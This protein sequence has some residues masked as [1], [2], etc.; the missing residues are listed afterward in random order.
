MKARASQQASTTRTVTANSLWYGLDSILGL[1]MVFL[2]S[3]PLARALGPE[4]LGYF[5]YVGW[6]CAMSGNLG[7][8][9]IPGTA[10]RF[11]ALYLGRS[12]GG[13]ARA[14]FRFAIRTQAITAAVLTIGGALL[15]LEFGDPQYRTVTLLQVA[16]ILPAMLGQ[17]ATFANMASEKLSRNVSGGL[18][19]NVVYLSGVWASL[20]FGWGLT[21]VAAAMLLSKSVE[22]ALR[23]GAA[24]QWIGAHAEE[25][26]SAEE[27][28]PMYR[29][30]GQ[31]LYVGL[32]AAI[33]WSKSDVVLLKWLSR[34]I[35]QVTFFTLACNIIDK[36]VTLPQIIGSAM[37]ISMVAQTGDDPGRAAA[38]TATATRYMFLLSAPLLFG[39]F[40]VASPAVRILYGVQYAETAPILALGAVLAVTKPLLNPPDALFRATGR[41]APMLVCATACTV[42]NM[43]LDVL[44]IPG[45][46]ALGATVGNGVSQAVLVI[47]YLAIAV[48]GFGVRMD[49]RAAAMTAL[50]AGAMMPA[51]LF[52]NRS[53]PA[54]AAL[55][56]DVGSGAIVYAGM[57]R[58][59]GVLGRA[60]LARIETITR[61]LPLRMQPAATSA[62]RV[63]AG[64]AAAS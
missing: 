3:V 29:F 20:A 14:V 36:V 18:A 23:F 31:Q 37:S 43:A 16:A 56:C 15:A 51:A 12:E 49:Y 44:L 63:L 60:D 34:D 50:S 54:P 39:T 8:L 42:L 17:I 7:N 59:T 40:L 33:L 52:F 32:L 1:L 5:N 30:A 2:T 62:A 24:G 47:G 28:R 41:Q 19:G 10:T 53:L 11:M 46:G 55:V 57:L 58:L 22:S 35:R 13:K 4:R 6:L 9:G 26:L 61:M 21:G 25:E 27:K 38:M 48:I 45:H 64:R